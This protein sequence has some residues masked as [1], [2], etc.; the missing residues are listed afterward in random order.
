[1]LN[2]KSEEGQ[3]RIQRK[4]LNQQI[5]T[6]THFAGSNFLLGNENCFKLDLIANLNLKMYYFQ[7]NIALVGA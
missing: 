4:I 2:F 1:M 3:Q 5:K 7:Q 6:S